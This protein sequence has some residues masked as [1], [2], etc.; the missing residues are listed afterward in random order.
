MY[1]HDEEKGKRLKIFGGGF[2][3]V[4]AKMNPIGFEYE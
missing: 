1:Q 4:N 3:W 2:G